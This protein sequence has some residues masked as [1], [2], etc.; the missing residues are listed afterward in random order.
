MAAIGILSVGY[1]FVARRH[2]IDKYKTCTSSAE[3]VTMQETVLNELEQSY[4]Q[5]REPQGEHWTFSDAVSIDSIWF[6]R[7]RQR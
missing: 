1:S 5:S 3:I 7:I 4:K 2:L 6:T